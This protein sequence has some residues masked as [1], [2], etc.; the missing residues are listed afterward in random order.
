LGTTRLGNE[1]Q[2]IFERSHTVTV[3]LGNYIILILLVSLSISSSAVS[4]F[5]HSAIGSRS[6]QRASRASSYLDAV[7]STLENYFVVLC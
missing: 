1:I 6:Q 3:E 4:N 7:A 2:K 5:F